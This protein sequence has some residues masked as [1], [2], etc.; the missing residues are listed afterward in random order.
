MAEERESHPVLLSRRND[1]FAWTGGLPMFGSELTLPQID[2]TT[3]KVRR[4][5]DN[6]HVRTYLNAGILCATVDGLV[7]GRIDDSKD[8]THIVVGVN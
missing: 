6:L 5:R 4:H 8:I 3:V 1:V 7:C 2:H